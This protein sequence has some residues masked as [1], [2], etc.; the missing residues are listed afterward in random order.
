MEN[1]VLYDEIG[2]SE[3]C[4]IY[5]GRRKGTV[6]FLAIYCI[7]KKKRAEVTNQVRLTHEIDHSNIVKFIEWYETTNHL[8]V[9]M[10]LCTGGGLDVIIRQDGHLPESAVKQ[11]GED[12][13]RGLHHIHCLG[14][15]YADLRPSKVMLDGAGHLKL[16]DF[17]LARVEG[18]NLEELLQMFAVGQEDVSDDGDGLAD[19]TSESYK[20][21]TYTKGS[22]AYMAP[23]VIEGGPHT[24]ATDLWSL[25]C[26]LY[27]L[28]TGHP[29]F[30]AEAYHDLVHQILH[31]DYPAPKVRGARLS[32]KPSPDFVDLL[33]QLLL[34]DPTARITWEGLLVHPFWSGAVKDLSAEPE[35]AP[36]RTDM[37]AATPLTRRSSVNLLELTKTGTSSLGHIKEVDSLLR[38]SVDRPISA[39]GRNDKDG[40]SDLRPKSALGGIE[41]TK[42]PIFA[43]SSKPKA[44]A[45]AELS[46]L[47]NQHELTMAA[48]PGDARQLLYWDNDWSVTPIVDNPWIQKQ[49]ALKYDIKV[50][51]VPPYTVEKIAAM[52]P[53]DFGK[54]LTAISDL[55]LAPEKGPPTQKRAHLMC[56]ATSVSDEP[57]AANFLV[58]RGVL[59][60][61]LKQLK[62]AQH[63]DMKLRIARLIG[64]IASSC[65][66]ADDSVNLTE[67]VSTLTDMV[68]ENFKNQKIKTAL[69]PALGEVLFMVARLEEARDKTIDTWSVPALTYALISKCLREGEEPV[70]HHYCCKIIEN[71]VTTR[72]QHCS[73]FL[74][75]E[76]GQSLWYVFT[77][78]AVDAPKITATLALMRITKL[79]VSVL[80]SVIEKTSGYTGFFSL[81]TTSGS[82]RVQQ[83]LITMVVEVVMSGQHRQKILQLKEL[84]AAAVRLLESTSAVVRGKAYL[85]ICQMVAASQEHLL[86]ACQQRLIAFIERDSKRHHATDGGN[87]DKLTE[88]AQQQHQTTYLTSCV[89]LLMTAIVDT[90]PSV[91]RD[92]VASLEAASGRKH[93]SAAQTKQLRLHLP[94]VPVL[95]Q[96]VGSS[97]FHAQVVNEGFLRQLGTLLPYVAETSRGQTGVASASA[98]PEDFVRSAVAIVE[99][100]SLH[101]SI[102]QQYH[103]IIVECI[104]DPLALLCLSDNG[105]A[106]LAALKLFT[107]MAAAIL[108]PST[109]L[110]SATAAAT[111]DSCRR[112]GSIVKAKLLPQYDQLLLDQN[113]LPVYALRLLTLLLQH[114]PSFVRDLNAD[115][116][117]A[118]L[119]EVLMDN[120]SNPASGTLRQAT[121]AMR[122]IISSKDAPMA[123]LHDMNVAASLSNLVEQLIPYCA[124]REHSHSDVPVAMASLEDLLESV[125]LVLKSASEVVRKALQTKQ[126]V[127]GSGSGVAPAEPTTEEAEELLLKNKPFTALLR[128]LP[129]LLC[130]ED[131][132][133]SELALKTLSLLVQLFGGDDAEAMNSANMAFYG[134]SLHTG[135]SKRQKVLLRILKRLV[136]TEKHN[137]HMFVT[138]GADLQ[139]TLSSLR[140]T[141]SAQ[142][143]IALAAGAAEVLKAAG[144]Q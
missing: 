100:I 10:E 127:A 84:L 52:Q 114:T 88:Q 71:I 22:P 55:L 99:A 12:L 144:L 119:F 102:I 92:L 31:T 62:D 123:A 25:G 30:V 98:G 65:T 40:W 4:T 57:R 68:R 11:F 37:R 42:P 6:T 49:G 139:K 86:T 107:E 136:T 131:A 8:W 20:Y 33:S 134:R 7:D 74:T 60:V 89:Q 13:V 32:A 133:M 35:R 24:M 130:V 106:K 64:H 116:V 45:V 132:D 78:S 81:L 141:A 95:S 124:D 47:G 58:K 122:C 109:D 120:A 128:H 129:A 76:I 111:K 121:A 82:Q 135:D 56:Y 5:K 48:E 110:P 26:V 43:L 77:H 143:D 67:V 1:F 96:V 118:A 59:P 93:P 69:L 97:A 63:V 34:K 17:G 19:D 2:K 28:F 9:V 80:E 21:K 46:T 91:L 87:S 44:S 73:K 36:T 16:S 29:P 53:K 101:P 90:V 140:Q 108:N 27:E 115:S 15:I 54:H 72:G 75:T 39:L 138:Q 137:T 51:P 83:S 41:E 105:D 142:A 126:A 3:H 104:L 18:E 113:P 70:V 125:H 61:L 79:S 112:L 117:L 85:L 23:E 103:N 14:L 38:R 50:L 66:A 94:M